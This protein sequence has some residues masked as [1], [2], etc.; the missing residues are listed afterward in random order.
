MKQKVMIET[1]IEVDVIH[2][3]LPVR[4][5]EE[6][7][8]NDF[9]HRTEKT[10]SL[11][12]KVDTGE[13]LFWDKTFP[14]ANV[15]M[16]VCDEGVYQLYGPNGELIKKLDGD[17][18]PHGLVPGEFGDYVHLHIVDGMIQNWPKYPKLDDFYPD[19]RE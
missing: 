2:M 16:K 10:L 14:P 9:P 7:I 3:E 17:Y 13:L 11:H 8:P 18:V 5:E 19:G 6:D 4:Y 15:E 1:E 12:V